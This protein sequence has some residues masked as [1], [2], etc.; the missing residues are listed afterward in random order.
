MLLNKDDCQLVLIDF[1]EKLMPAI[2]ESEFVLKN[3]RILAAVAKKMRVPVFGTE[4]MPDKLG[5][6]DSQLLSHCKATLVKSHFNACQEGLGDLLTPKASSGNAR[7]LPKHL[8]KN[9]AQ[10]E[11]STILIAGVEAHI[12]LLQS[13]LDLL[14]NEH[15]VWVVTDACGSRTEKNRDAAFDRLAGFGAELV[16]TEMVVYEWLESS[17]NEDFK[18]CL[19]LIK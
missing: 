3:A 5:R 10:T 18:F 13:A 16:T 7:S 14:E 6:F 2:H 19:D 4:Q 8:Q 15:E 17:D 1:Q 11:R 9:D 12:C